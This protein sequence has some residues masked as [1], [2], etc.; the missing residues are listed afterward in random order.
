MS[1]I[2]ATTSSWLC[3]CTSGYVAILS[4]ASSS[5][6]TGSSHNT[7]ANN[8]WIFVIDAGVSSQGGLGN[9]MIH[10]SRSR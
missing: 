2:A 4:N 10:F 7:V 8:E 5:T 1:C 9:A 6:I 3:F